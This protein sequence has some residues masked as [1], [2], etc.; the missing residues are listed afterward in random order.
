M[1]PTP[2][3]IRVYRNQTNRF[4]QYLGITCTEI[5]EGYAKAVLPIKDELRNPQGSVHGGV[6]Y[7]L[8]DVAAGNAA[9][10][11]GT[12][13]ATQNSDIYFL[14]AGLSLTELVAEATV[15]K[16]GKRA[17]IVQVSI[18]DQD[19]TELAVTTLNF[20]SLGKPIEIPQA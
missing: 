14:R 9:S 3:E 7:T 8:A 2:E 4:A 17:N 10:S 12:M 18:Q 11:Y 5:R 20:A 15:I 19:G 1:T 13:I 16:H 6:I